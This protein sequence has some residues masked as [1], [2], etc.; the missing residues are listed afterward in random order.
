MTSRCPDVLMEGFVLPMQF[1]QRNRPDAGERRLCLAIF[2]GAVVDATKV[3]TTPHTDRARAWLASPQNHPFSARWIADH[4]GLD[5]LAVLAKLAV[6]E[7]ITFGHRGIG[8]QAV[9]A[10]AVHDRRG[11]RASTRGREAPPTHP[12]RR[13]RRPS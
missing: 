9:N 10:R 8:P 6:A 12:W 4:M 13:Y 5:L 3:P 1:F 7:P 2:E 11:P